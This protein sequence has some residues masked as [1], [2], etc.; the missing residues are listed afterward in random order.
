MLKLCPLIH[1][2][3]KSP[4]QWQGKDKVLISK[5]CRHCGTLKE[6][7]KLIDIIRKYAPIAINKIRGILDAVSVQ[8][9][10]TRWFRG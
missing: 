5:R 9:R 4:K 8:V 10:K 2:W 6:E 3:S 7:G 1:W